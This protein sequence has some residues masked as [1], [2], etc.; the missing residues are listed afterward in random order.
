ML[1]YLSVR[2]RSRLLPE[3]YPRSTPPRDGALICGMKS[4]PEIEQSIESRI[5]VV[6]GQRVMLGFDLARLYGVEVKAL[7]QA[8][9]RN[10]DRFPSDFMFQLS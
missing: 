4:S 9:R 6:R 2:L 3:R 7:S 1:A 8:V 5:L 10:M